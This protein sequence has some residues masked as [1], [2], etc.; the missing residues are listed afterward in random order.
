MLCYN[1]E[2][3]V[4]EAL[5]GVFAQSYSP[6]EIVIVDD[7][8]TDATAEIVGARLAGIR[9]RPNVRFIRN[10]WNSGLLG[11]CETGIK[12][13]T[14]EFIIFT[15]DDDV[16]LPDMVSEMADFWQS[17]NASLVTTNAA[18]IDEDSNPLGRT[19]RD[20]NSEADDS[21]ETLVRDGANACCFGATMGF[22]PDIYTK[23]GMPPAHLNNIDILYPFY[24]GVLN[25]T[26]YLNKPLLKYRVH[27]N[28]GSLS[29]MEERS[30]ERGK[31]EVRD[32]IFYGHIAH[33]VVMMEELD[34]LCE[35][36][37]E[38]YRE[39]APRVGPLLSIQAVEMA[40][41]L[42]RNRIQLEMLKSET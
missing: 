21:F 28:N 8:S 40:K 13:A 9:G 36:M 4:S 35:V 15:C 12:A 33:A 10:A 2:R 27:G 26:R 37:P 25:G 34:R 23:F 31:L 24:A 22:T 41:K 29:L 39:L 6:L 18:L 30:G 19:F 14:G 20:L 38:R 5:A 11:A 1:H 42:V 3:Y 32:R 7:C 16:M 17:T